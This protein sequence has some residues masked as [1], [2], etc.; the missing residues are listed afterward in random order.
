M[1]PDQLFALQRMVLWYQLRADQ[2]LTLAANADL[3]MGRRRIAAA[4]RRWFLD[5]AQKALD[6]AAVHGK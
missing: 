1:T 2:E 3:P 5:L 6:R 4:R